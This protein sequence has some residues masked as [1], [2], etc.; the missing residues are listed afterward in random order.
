MQLPFR[1]RN[2]PNR[3]LKERSGI[4][5]YK[6]NIPLVIQG[7]DD[8]GERI[9]ISLMT[10]DLAKARALRDVYERADDELWASLAGGIDVDG[11]RSRYHAA[12][13][14]ARA[15]GFAYRPAHEIA[16]GGV[17]AILERIEAILRP[18]TPKPIVEAVLG[19][20]EAPQT[21]VRQA[22][23]IYEEHITPHQ[24]A[25]KSKNQKRK[26]LGGKKGAIEHFIEVCGDVAMDELTREHGRKYFEHWSAKI[27]PQGG[28]ATHTADQGNRRIGDMRVFYR[29]YFSYMN[30]ADRPN[31][32][33]RLSFKKR[34][35]RKR[36]RPSFSQNWIIDKI[37][38]PG[39]LARLNDEARA[40]LL[41]VANVGARPSEICN[42]T[43]ERIRLA[44]NIPHIIIEP[45]EDPDDPREIKT[46]SS[47][48]VVPLAGMALESMR[49][50]PKG[51]ARYRDRGDSLSAALNKFM[52]ENGLR[53]TPKHSVY[54]FRHSF[55]DRMKNVKVDDEVRKILMGHALDRPEYGE[56]G[57]L[58]LKLEAMTA[59][60][61]PYDP[62]IV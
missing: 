57:S 11:A 4:Y 40:I 33:D 5:Y 30:Q 26:W 56:G 29:E 6:R 17:E 35:K 51:F 39:A 12:V 9:R 23:A 44:S 43:P 47:I 42:L 36:K 50:F 14:R 53:E 52:E 61:L 8:R 37:L 19:T 31:P 38:K 54:S 48:R 3:Y 25:G 28:R 45:D 55:E 16:G 18:T 13:K 21:S 15:L 60:A 49:K 10:D 46:E 22:W 41:I 20:V 24:I 34:N 1:K 62:S 58:N 2:K 59:V 32:F 27:A 7:L